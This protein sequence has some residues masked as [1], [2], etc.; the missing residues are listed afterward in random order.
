ML[1]VMIN[2]L[3]QS[4][5]YIFSNLQTDSSHC[6]SHPGCGVSLSSPHSRKRTQVGKWFWSHFS[7]K[8]WSSLSFWLFME[9]WLLKRSGSW[10][11]SIGI[12]IVKVTETLIPRIPLSLELV[13]LKPLWEV[14]FCYQQFPCSTSSAS[15]SEKRKSWSAICEALT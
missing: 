10:S 12:R 1:T 5:A 8:H 13:A 15:S 2:G 9:W 6:S 3:L 11:G 7:W 14:F 4:V